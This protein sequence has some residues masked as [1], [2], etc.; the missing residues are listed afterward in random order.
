MLNTVVVPLTVDLQK[1]R[2][3]IRAEVIRVVLRSSDEK[4]A[5][6]L[7]FVMC[8]GS[9]SRCKFIELRL[10]QR[11]TVDRANSLYDFLRVDEGL[12]KSTTG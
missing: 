2:S 12:M 5:A 9:A 3:Q 10:R 6:L 11:S 4:M 1:H 7:L 8:C